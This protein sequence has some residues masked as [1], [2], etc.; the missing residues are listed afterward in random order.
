MKKSVDR[1]VSSFFDGFGFFRLFFFFFVVGIEGVL[2]LFEGIFF[3]GELV[4]FGDWGENGVGEGALGGGV[5]RR[6]EWDADKE[7]K[8]VFEFVPDIFDVCQM[9]L[10]D[11][12]TLQIHYT[13]VYYP[14]IYFIPFS[15]F[16]C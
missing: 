6:G 13:E 15:Y 11:K 9:H 3:D 10:S 2:E 16:I 8:T 14:T 7:V 12:I 1:S 5:R 4:G